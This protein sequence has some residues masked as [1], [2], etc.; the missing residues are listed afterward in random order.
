M[1]FLAGCLQNKDPRPTKPRPYY[2]T[3]TPYYKTK[4]D[5]SG[6]TKIAI[7]PELIGGSPPNFYHTSNKDT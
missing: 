1:V 4:T 6:N 5:K 2:K 3:K 7:I